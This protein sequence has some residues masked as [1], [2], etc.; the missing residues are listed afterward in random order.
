M[1]PRLPL[2]CRALLCV[3][4]MNAPADTPTPAPK[5]RVAQAEAG[6]VGLVSGTYVGT[7]VDGRRLVVTAQMLTQ[8]MITLQRHAYSS[9]PVTFRRVA[10]T[11]FQDRDGNTLTLV[12][13][14]HLVWRDLRG[15][16]PVSYAREE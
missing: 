1:R 5:P 10:P 7:W 2:P 14:V 12:S 13:P 9:A 15:R 11:L 6:Q 16:T 8:D 4:P 3:L